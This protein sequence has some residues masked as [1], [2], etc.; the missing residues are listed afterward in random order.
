MRVYRAVSLALVVILGGIAV[1]ETLPAH[2]QSRSHREPVRSATATWCWTRMLPT[3]PVDAVPYVLRGNW[4]RVISRPCWQRRS[5]RRSGPRPA[6]GAWRSLPTRS[7][8]RNG[9]IPEPC[10]D[11]LGIG[12]GIGIGIGVAIGI[13]I[14]I[15]IEG[16][17][18]DR[19]VRFERSIQRSARRYSDEPER[20]SARA[21]VCCLLRCIDPVRMLWPWKK[22][23]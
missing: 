6:S 8:P 7:W 18:C 9:F 13:A 21:S 14:A 22:R 10:C 12:I 15:A 16:R 3:A 20:G 4:R 17:D 1:S 19:R 2:R 5:S 23:R 11:S